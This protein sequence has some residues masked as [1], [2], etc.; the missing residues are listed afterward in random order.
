MRACVQ[1]C[2]RDEGLLLACLL[3]SCL[4]G[5]ESLESKTKNAHNMCDFGLSS[6]RTVGNLAVIL[7]QGDPV[8]IGY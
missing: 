6:S 2:A 7:A 8:H 3:G 5:G 1:A 4:L